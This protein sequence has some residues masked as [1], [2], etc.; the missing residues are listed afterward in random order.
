MAAKQG[1]QNLGALRALTAPVMNQAMFDI[2]TNKTYDP[3]KYEQSIAGKAPKDLGKIIGDSLKSQ[4]ALGGLGISKDILEEI[5]YG[6]EQGIMLG[7]VELL[8]KI[9]DVVSGI[10]DVMRHPIKALEDKFPKTAA[11]VEDVGDIVKGYV[12]GIWDT[13]KSLI[14]S[15]PS[16]D[17]KI[18]VG[19]Q[20]LMDM[21]VSREDAAAMIGNMTQESSMNPYAQNQ[22]HAGLGQWDKSR[23]ED[24][25]RKYGY[26]PGASPVPENKQMR[27]Q[28]EFAKYET[29]TTHRAVAV[30]M[31]K[32]QG[33][34][35]KTKTFMDLDERP[36]DD[37]LGK[38]IGYAQ[39][40]D[41][42]TS[43]ADMIGATKNKTYV[44]QNSVSHETTINGGINV[45]TPA[46]DP[47]AQAAAMKK[48]VTGQPLINLPSQGTISL[49]TRGMSNY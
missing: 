49:A 1:Y 13:A 34:L 46:T 29:E 12:T 19:M 32:A 9:L 26:L 48:A 42:L 3:N 40:A 45:T 31:K 38:R 23:Q 14:S 5:A 47:H 7:V 20:T 37:S 28:L 15:S 17:K 4:E 25:R 10:F 39:L 43:A 41:K 11:V 35:D 21:G 18:L 33:I 2:A 27:D 44:L 24:F 36:G 8:R 30:A 6:G 22:G 16:L